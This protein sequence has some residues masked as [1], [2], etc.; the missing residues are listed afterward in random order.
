MPAPAWLI[1]LAA[2]EAML[3][4]PLM[5]GIVVVAVVI[6]VVVLVVMVVVI[7]AATA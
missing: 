4:A 5:K 6:V 1:T 7:E 2:V 3:G